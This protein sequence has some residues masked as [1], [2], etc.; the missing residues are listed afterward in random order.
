MQM[1]ADDIFLKLRNGLVRLDKEIVA[2]VESQGLDPAPGSQAETERA[3][4]PN[5][6]SLYTVSG[7][8]SILLESV[9]EHV[10]LLVRAMH[11]P[12]TPF[13]CWTCVRSMLES[14][15]ISAWL[16]D[17][18]IDAQKRVSR[19]YAHRY[20]GLEEQ[21]KFVRA[22]NMPAGE[23]KKH[24]DLL[25][26]L[27]RDAAALGLSAIRNR[28]G[29]RI[30]LAESMPSATDIIKLMLNEEM[31]YRA[32]SA[33]A[34][35]HTWAMLPLGFKKN[36]GP[37]VQHPNGAKTTL[38]EKSAGS[39]QMHAFHAVRAAKALVLPVLNQSLYFGWDKDRLVSVLESVYDDIGMQPVTRFWR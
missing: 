36:S 33:V 20:Q 14:S 38:M 23:V 1:T 15:A 30:G 34:H 37:Q 4:Y 24:E 2:F 16:H 11:E 19:A 17:P 3:N 10:S 26:K 7:I 13:A 27:E 12:I 32:L 5:P 31:A 6:E 21:A 9:S 29:D 22:A 18:K 39:I 28:K 25:D 35:A 8:C